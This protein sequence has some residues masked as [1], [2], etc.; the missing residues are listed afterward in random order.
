[1]CQLL[2]DIA[3]KFRRKNADIHFLFRASL[4]GENL[5]KIN[6]AIYL[7]VN[8]MIGLFVIILNLWLSLCFDL[9]GDWWAETGFNLLV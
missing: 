3:A 8:G 6:S 1:M 5:V 7:S 9:R 2:L 4:L